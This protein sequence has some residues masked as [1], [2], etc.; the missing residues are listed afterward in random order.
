[1]E[2][3]TLVNKRIFV[4]FRRKGFHAYPGAPE[5]VGYL[6]QRHRHIFWFKVVIDVHHENR[7][8]EFHQFLNWLESLYDTNNLELNNKSCE[9]ISTELYSHILAR[10]GNRYVRIEVVE[11]G[12]NG[13]ETE[14]I[15]V[16]DLED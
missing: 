5:D 13:C 9:M 2:N 7:E 11:D 3:L 12:E 14:F 4:T 15:P 1:M 6:E 8:I 10:Y 16:N